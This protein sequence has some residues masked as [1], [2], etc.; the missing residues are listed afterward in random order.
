[1]TEPEEFENKVY[2]GYLY[3]EYYL[4]FVKWMKE[5][6]PNWKPSWTLDQVQF[7]N[8]LMFWI[9]NI[10]K[11]KKGMTELGDKRKVLKMIYKYYKDNK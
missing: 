4:N 3:Y 5:K 11:L 9:E 7:A 8:E 1:M 6:D 2:G 10:S